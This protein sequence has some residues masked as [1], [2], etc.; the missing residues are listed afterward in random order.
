MSI[1][2]KDPEEEVRSDLWHKMD[3]KQLD[4]QRLLISKKLGAIRGL[5]ANGMTNP[6]TQGLHAAL[7]YAMET[8]NKLLTS[9]LI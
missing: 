4:N 5:M 9:K 2:E 7:E 1:P 3:I 8:V 6:T